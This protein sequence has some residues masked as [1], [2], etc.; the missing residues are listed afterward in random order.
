LLRKFSWRRTTAQ[1][2]R[3][4]AGTG[5]VTRLARDVG[6]CQVHPSELEMF[7]HELYW[8]TYIIRERKEEDR[9]GKNDVLKFNKS[10]SIVHSYGG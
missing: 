1:I 10:F 7:E 9:M 4:L 8:W 6:W 5:E 2:G 3:E